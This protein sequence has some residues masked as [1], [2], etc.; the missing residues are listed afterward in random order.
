[1]RLGLILLFRA[2][3]D[4]CVLVW[5]TTIFFFEFVSLVSLSKKVDNQHFASVWVQVTFSAIGGILNTQEVIDLCHGRWHKGVSDFHISKLRCDPRWTYGHARTEIAKSR[6]WTIRRDNDKRQRR[7]WMQDSIQKCFT[8]HLRFQRRWTL[9][10]FTG[11][12]PFRLELYGT[13]GRH[14]WSLATRCDKNKIYPEIE[15]HS[16]TE[17]N[18]IYD[19]RGEYHGWMDS[20]G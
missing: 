5:R 7:W 2:R 10:F 1:M 6:T 11:C 17:L 9:S 19:A 18:R 14:T 3:L 15:I 16:V 8:P 20:D 13:F 4:M 12:K